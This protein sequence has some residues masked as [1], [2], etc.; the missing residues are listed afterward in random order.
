MVLIYLVKTTKSELRV[1]SSGGQRIT[2]SSNSRRDG[3][4]TCSQLRL[5][6][7]FLHDFFVCFNIQGSQRK[8]CNDDAYNINVYNSIIRNRI[9]LANRCTAAKLSCGLLNSAIV[10]CLLNQFER[11][12]Y[13]CHS[14]CNDNNIP[15]ISVMKRVRLALDVALGKTTDS[16][17]SSSGAFILKLS[18]GQD[19]HDFRLNNRGLGGGIKQ[20]ISYQIYVAN[21][22]KNGIQSCDELVRRD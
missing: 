2:Y 7:L 19:L 20:K 9:L 16:Q 14:Q 3:L 4:F 15:Y 10:Q 17:R 11:N 1:S 21:C 18:L 13:S 22:S 8:L 5:F 6:I 12:F